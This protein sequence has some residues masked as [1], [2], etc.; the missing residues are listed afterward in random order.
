MIICAHPRW[1]WWELKKSQGVPFIF[2]FES[3]TLYNVHQSKVFSKGEIIGLP[4]GWTG[5][6]PTSRSTPNTLELCRFSLIDVYES[7]ICSKVLI[8]DNYQFADWDNLFSMMRTSLVKTKTKMQ[9][10]FIAFLVWLVLL[11]QHMHVLFHR[12]L[13]MLITSDACIMSS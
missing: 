6:S 13:M 12:F 5:S 7:L 9:S 4:H 10:F 1:E 8:D 2:L 3:Y 11:S